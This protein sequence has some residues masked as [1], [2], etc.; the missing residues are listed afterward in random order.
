MF[1]IIKKAMRGDPKANFQ[2]K[3]QNTLCWY[4]YHRY[5]HILAAGKSGPLGLRG[6]ES[7]SNHE[8]APTPAR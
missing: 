3:Y 8:V 6:S 1:H 5:S 4:V 7:F 2:P